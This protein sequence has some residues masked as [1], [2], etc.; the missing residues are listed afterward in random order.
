MGYPELV[1]EVFR[2]AWS[3]TRTGTC[4]RATSPASAS[5]VDEEL[6]RPVPVRARLPAG[7][8]PPRRHPH[9]LVT[10]DDPRRLSAATTLPTAA[11]APPR[12]AARPGSCTSD[13]ATSTGRT[14]PCTPPP[15][16]P[17]RTARGA[18]S[19]WP[20]AR[21]GWPTRW[22][23]RTS[24]TRSWRSR[25]TAPGSTSRPCTP[26]R[27]SPPASR[28]AGAGRD[29][30]PAHPDRHLT[31]TENGYTADPRT[32]GLDLDHPCVARRP[33]RTPR[34]RRPRIGQLV[35]GLQRRRTT[36]RRPDHRP[37]LRQPGLG[38]GA[39]PPRLVG[40]VPAGRAA[41]RRARTTGPFLARVA[42]PN[43]M[44]DRIVPATTD[45]YRE[46]R[47]AR[48]LGVATPSRCRPSRSAC[49]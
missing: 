16:W 12:A 10:A 48:A 35:R 42:F 17:P 49:G 11:A 4:T 26:A 5:S 31:V 19:A 3:R 24:A 30:R 9:G 37:E 25:R 36:R 28:R 23:P 1:H 43:A 40:R 32:G 27:W 46:R 15:R 20:A 22:P 41:R 45:A 2:H 33:A 34:P 7:R 39:H 44:V 8:A 14:R 13:S 47:V 38:N 6:R 21:V 29:R 18:S